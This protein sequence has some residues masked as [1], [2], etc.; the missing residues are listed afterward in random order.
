MLAAMQFADSFLPAGSF[1][2]S[3]GIEAFVAADDVTDAADVQELLETYM[4]R[5][6]GPCEMVAL[7]AAHDT[8]MAGDVA[9]LAA[10]DRRLTA[11]QLPAE[12]RESSRKT[13][14]QLLALALETDP[15][16]VLSAYEERVD[17]DEAAWHYPVVLGAVGAGVGLDARGAAIAL[18]YAFVRDLLAATQRVLRLGHTDIQRVLTALRPT[19][20]EAWERYGHRPLSEMTAFAPLVDV[21]SMEHERAERRLFIS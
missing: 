16:A 3:Y 6:L 10:V 8:A 7:S 9:A 21:A 12:F 14:S 4:R 13:G 15:T 2:A 20:V 1:T 18:G 19:I 17:A 11:A 5:Q